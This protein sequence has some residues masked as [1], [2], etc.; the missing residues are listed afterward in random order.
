MAKNEKL[1]YWKKKKKY[2]NTIDMAIEYQLF[3]K[4]M[5]SIPRDQHLNLGALFRKLDQK[6][7]G[8]MSYAISTISKFW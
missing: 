6:W 2:S 4:N 5:F 7:F 8:K 3:N 1:S